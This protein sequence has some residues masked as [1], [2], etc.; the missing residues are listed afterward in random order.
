MQLCVLKNGHICILRDE[1]I[2]FRGVTKVYGALGNA[3]ENATPFR[4]LG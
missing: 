4:L 1:Y 2:S 3:V